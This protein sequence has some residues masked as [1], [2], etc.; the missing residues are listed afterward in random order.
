MKLSEL[1]FIGYHVSR[2]RVASM[3]S[4]LTA[5]AWS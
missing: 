1:V 4:R 2:T 3:L 5:T